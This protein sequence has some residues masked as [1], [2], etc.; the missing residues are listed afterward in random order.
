MSNNQATKISRNIKKERKKVE[1]VMNMKRKG[2]DYNERKQNRRLF[3]S[4]RERER[5][6]GSVEMKRKIEDPMTITR[7]KAE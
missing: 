1:G 2:T 5:E 6:G 3:I 4:E 7:K